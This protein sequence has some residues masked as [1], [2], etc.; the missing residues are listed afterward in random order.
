[1][2]AVLDHAFLTAMWARSLARVHTSIFVSVHNTLS[3]VNKNSTH[4]KERVVSA[5]LH[6]HYPRA[7]KIIAVS[8]GVA[9]D[10]SMALSIPRSHVLTIYNPVITPL[11]HER[12][13]ESVD[14]SWFEAGQPPVVLGI[15]RLTRQKDFGTLIHAFAEVVKRRPARLVILGEGEDR[16][17]LEMQVKQ[18]GLE[19]SVCL[20][21]FAQNP[22]AY[23]ARCGA[24]VLSSLWEG[25]PTVLIE[26]LACGAPVVATD[27]PNGPREIL[28]D[29]AWGSLV[30]CA[31]PGIMAARIIEALDKPAAHQPSPGA[32]RFTID[33]VVKQYLALL[34]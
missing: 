7:D 11:M 3:R 23:L 17:M 14:H 15:G 33:N 30:P 22:Y 32:T 9:E 5:L 4:V 1:M 12:A 18:L 20:P 29:G 24:F 10:V 31:D 13:A 28:E 27:C 8:D 2:I 19:N 16:H 26:A 21:G 25:L 34:G 6:S